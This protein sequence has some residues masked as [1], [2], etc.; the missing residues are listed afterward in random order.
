M[1][2]LYATPDSRLGQKHGLD[3]CDFWSNQSKT[4]KLI[5]FKVPE[6][7]YGFT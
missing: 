7:P 1:T 6:Q 2:E 5:A 3:Q 4:I